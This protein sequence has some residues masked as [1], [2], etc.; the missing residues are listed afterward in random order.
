MNPVIVLRVVEGLRCEGCGAVHGYVDRRTHLC[1]HCL[2][3][4]LEV[5]RRKDNLEMTL[6]GRFARLARKVR[7]QLAEFRN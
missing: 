4:R 6:A 3:L 1:L 2:G 7:E 5:N